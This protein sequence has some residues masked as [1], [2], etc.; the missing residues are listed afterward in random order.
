MPPSA[1]EAIFARRLGTLAV[2]SAMAGYTDVIVSQW[3][4]EFVLVPLELVVPG[5][6]RVPLD[7]MFGRRSLAAPAKN[8]STAWR[9]TSRLIDPRRRA[10]RACRA[11]GDE[12]AGL[13]V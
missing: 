1:T 13:M 12:L 2:D 10:A 3:L 7:G 9:R 6:K 4:T 5:R 8:C 11:A